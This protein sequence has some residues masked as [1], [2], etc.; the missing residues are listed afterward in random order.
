MKKVGWINFNTFLLT[1]IKTSALRKLQ[2]F[3]QRTITMTYF[4]GDNFTFRIRVSRNSVRNY[5]VIDHII[6]YHLEQNKDVTYLQVS[7][8]WYRILFSKQ[9]FVPGLLC[10]NIMDFVSGIRLQGYRLRQFNQHVFV[11]QN[12]RSTDSKLFFITIF[13]IL[14]FI[15]LGNQ[16]LQI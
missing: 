9:Y 7:T 1:S 3:C 4:E 6:L 16:K 11:Q 2:H 12:M 15:S 5:W 10:I 13:F 8:V 14:W